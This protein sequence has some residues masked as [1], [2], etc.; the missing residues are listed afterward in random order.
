MLNVLNAWTWYYLLLCPSRLAK[1]CDEYVCVCVS[2]CS[3]N[4]KTAWP[5]FTKLFVHV[6]CGRCSVLL[7]QHCNMLC[8]T[9]IV[10]DVMF[11]YHGTNGQMALDKIR[12]EDRLTSL[13]LLKLPVPSVTSDSYSV[14]QTLSQCSTR[15]KSDSYDWLVMSGKWTEWNWWIY[16]FHF[17]P[18]V[19]PS[20]NTHYI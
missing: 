1:Y 4:S 14:W 9:A 20:V 6:A 15:G 18:C 10:D 19:C 2:V 12:L 3:H 8:S 7:W 16:C 17:C 5:N 13:T 11:S